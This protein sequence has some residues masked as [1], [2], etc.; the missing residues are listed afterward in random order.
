MKLKLGFVFFPDNSIT[1]NS[2]Q[3]INLNYQND[4]S[5]LSLTLAYH[6][7]LSISITS[8]RFKGMYTEHI[9]QPITVVMN[10]IQKY[11]FV[12]TS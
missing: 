12:Y 8:P 1:Y 4:N 7:I 2:K 5:D 6:F 11:I 3:I 10:T 9:W